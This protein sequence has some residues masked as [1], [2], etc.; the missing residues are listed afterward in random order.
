MYCLHCLLG[1]ATVTKE[2]GSVPFLNIFNIKHS[3]YT[4]FTCIFKTLKIAIA[5]AM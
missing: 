5:T 4:S 3:F 2:G 1:I